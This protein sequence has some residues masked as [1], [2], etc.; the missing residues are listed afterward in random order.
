MKLCHLLRSFFR[1]FVLS[2]RWSRMRRCY[3]VFWWCAVRW[4]DVTI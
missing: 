1:E 2:S 4:I 3:S